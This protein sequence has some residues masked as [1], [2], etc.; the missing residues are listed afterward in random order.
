MPESL[1][2][3]EKELQSKVYRSLMDY[4]KKFPDHAFM[5]R[6][7]IYAPGR[8]EMYDSLFIPKEEIGDYAPYAPRNVLKHYSG[9]DSLSVEKER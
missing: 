3:A 1:R 2:S 9:T 4:Q 8:M 7:Q 5:R 6:Y